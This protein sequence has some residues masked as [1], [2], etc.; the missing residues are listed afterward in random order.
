ML[1]NVQGGTHAGL[2]R[3]PANLKCLRCKDHRKGASMLLCDSCDAPWHTFC[4]PVPLSEV[5]DGDW[6][7]PDC[8]DAGI[9]LRQLALHKQTYIPVE[10]SRPALELPSPQRMAMAREV[11]KKWH[12]V[13]IVHGRDGRERYERITF[14]GILSP[15]WFRVDW[16]DGTSSQH[17][18]AFFKHCGVLDEAAVPPS[19]LAAPPPVTVAITVGPLIEEDI[20]W[21]ILTGDDLAIRLWQL[22]PG[23]RHR[24]E[25]QLMHKSLARRPRATLTR[26]STSA[27]VNILFSVIN[28][29]TCR[30]VLDPW[31][32]NKAVHQAF[33][34]RNLFVANDRLGRKGVSLQYEPMEHVS[35]TK[36]A[37]ALGAINAIVTIPPPLLLDLAVVTAVEFATS[38]ACFGVP[39]EW[40]EADHIACAAYFSTLAQEQRLLWIRPAHP[41]AAFG[42]LCIFAT[43]DTLQARLRPM[44]RQSH[45]SPHAWIER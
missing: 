17:H 44:H 12:A 24:L 14:Q 4:L 5:P 13:A 28:L 39:I 34:S 25:T 8:T 36:M 43:A 21:S 1:T 30:V 2:T 15:K 40:A 9:T 22:M 45:Y 26:Q 3:P 38:V 27:F 16:S 19:V 31:A 35:Y 23:P 29:D 41:D 10:P 11:A 37:R 6:L 33:G 18:A 7:C 42:W 20:H 32:D